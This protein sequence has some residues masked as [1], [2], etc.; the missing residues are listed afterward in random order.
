ME[1][2]TFDEVITHLQKKKD[3]ILYSWEM[4]LAWPM[5]EV[6]FHIMHYTIF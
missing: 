3:H 4:V 5:I 1:L 6:S 2:M